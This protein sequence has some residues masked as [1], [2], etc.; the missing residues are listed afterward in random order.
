MKT[1]EEHPSFA[2]EPSEA[3]PSS[4]LDS[5]NRSKL[6]SPAACSI[7]AH[8][9]S[10]SSVCHDGKHFL[11]LVLII[12]TQW[13]RKCEQ[14]IQTHHTKGLLISATASHRPRAFEDK[15]PFVGWFVC[16]WNPQGTP[17]L[18][19]T[20]FCLPSA[21][22]FSSDWSGHKVLLVSADR[23]AAFNRLLCELYTSHLHG[24]APKHHELLST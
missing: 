9:W 17:A 19:R 3:W 21:Q 14:S 24:T 22:F 12:Q 20:P 10:C 6:L 2:Q 4:F 16:L 23:S 18:G 8:Q 15:V 7:P 1:Q 11:S 13:Q 5:P